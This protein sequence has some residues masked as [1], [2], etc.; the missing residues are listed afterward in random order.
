VLFSHLSRIQQDGV[1]LRRTYLS[2]LMLSGLVVFP[3][4]AGMAV[5]AREFVR[6]VLGPQWALAATIVPWFA[7]AAGCSVIS[8]LSQMV[9]EARADLN[10]SIA[11]QGAYVVALVAFLLVAV[12]YRSHGVWV[13]A[14]AVV[15]AELVR[16]VGYLGLMRRSVKFTFVDLWASFAPA[17]FTSA[18]VAL[19]V[20]ATR[21]LLD[22][23]V[24]TLVVF[25]A[26]V[27]AGT[28]ALTVCVRVCPLPAV[29]QELWLRLTAAGL[30]GAPGE[31]RWRLAPL[32]LGRP[33][34][35]LEA[36]R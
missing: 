22:G 32:A 5:A 29:R 20:A 23:A 17:A 10:R 31:L 6:V 14:A 30:L 11:V 35:E 28:L 25:A 7:L 2:M 19:A 12:E 34:R 9:A 15:A 36:S 24:P 18:G 26:E 4:C 21:V 16:L 13:Y 3:V 1:R 8:A 33:P 27:V